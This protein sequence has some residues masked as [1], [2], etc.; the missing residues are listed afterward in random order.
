MEIYKYCSACGAENQFGR[1]D[2]NERFHC[3]KC[4]TI[5]YQNPKP[6][7]TLICAKGNSILLGKR[8]FNPAKGEWGLPG[9]FMELNE[10]LNQAAL[11]ELKEETQL[12]GTVSQILGTCS[13]FGSIFGDVLLIG[14]EVKITDW[15]T[16]C[17]GD[18]VAE[19]QLFDINE[20]P[21]L[22]FHCHKKI[23]SYYLDIN[24]KR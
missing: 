10:T 14:L 13:H 16:M 11:R 15:S 5:H 17:A 7:A 22:A 2:G 8:A 1:I 19:L 24:H 23:I 20:L 9:G 12:T 4:S 6:T 18:D 21:D 3:V